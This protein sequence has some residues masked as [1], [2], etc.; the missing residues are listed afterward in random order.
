MLKYD[1]LAEVST[2]MW[3]VERRRDFSTNRTARSAE[4]FHNLVKVENNLN[5]DVDEENGDERK[6]LQRGKRGD[7][8][9]RG[10]L[11]Y[12]YV[13]ILDSFRAITIQKVQ[14]YSIFIS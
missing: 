1:W 9:G 6:H 7:L 12:N 4:Q 3:L 2:L 10:V 11:N 13:F 14:V 5:T 8:W